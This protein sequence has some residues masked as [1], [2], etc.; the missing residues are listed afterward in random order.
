MGSNF[1]KAGTGW[2]SN[3]GKAGT[4]WGN[5]CGKAGTGWVATVIGLALDG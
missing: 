1:G 5:N 2:G 4:G 3:F